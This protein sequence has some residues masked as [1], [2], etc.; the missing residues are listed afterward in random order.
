MMLVVLVSGCGGKSQP[1]RFY[2]LSATEKNQSPPA[3]S[4]TDKL[5]I[6]IGPVKLADYLAQSR[7]VTRLDVNKINRAEF[8]QWAGSLKNIV[9][10]VLADN[11]GTRLNTE[12]VFLYPW[13]SY[14]SIDYQVELEVTRFDSQPGA[15][16]TLEARWVV[17]RGTD[18]ALVDIKRST[19]Q[20]PIGGSDYEAMVAAQSNALG[21]LSSDIADAIAAATQK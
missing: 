16:A 15:M 19:I 13:R 6:G 18:K 5:S 14:V 12:K 21:R 20:E 11:I 3:N 17:L 4:S 10:I 1:T 9:E 2:T 8:D 7:I